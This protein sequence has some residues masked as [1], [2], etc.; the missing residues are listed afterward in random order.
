MKKIK[1][2]IAPPQSME[3][4]GQEILDYCEQETTSK[5]EVDEF[6]EELEDMKTMLEEWKADNPEEIQHKKAS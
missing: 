3:A 5:V 6:I 2:K 4:L 1:S